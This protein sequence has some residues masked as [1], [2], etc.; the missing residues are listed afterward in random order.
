[1]S[2]PCLDFERE[3]AALTGKGLL[4]REGDRY[5]SLVLPKKA[6]TMSAVSRA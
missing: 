2:R 3:V 4:F 1:L 5:L 6:P